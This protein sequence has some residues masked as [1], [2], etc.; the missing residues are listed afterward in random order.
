MRVK[1]V[2]SSESPNMD[3]WKLCM[4]ISRMCLILCSPCVSW[5]PLSSCLCAK[6]RKNPIVACRA[7][8]SSLDAVTMDPRHK[9]N[10]NT[11][12]QMFQVAKLSEGERRQCP[13]PAEVR[14]LSGFIPTPASQR[15]NDSNPASARSRGGAD[16][17]DGEGQPIH[18]AA[19]IPNRHQR[20]N[21]EVKEQ[22]RRTS[23]S[24]DA[25][26][27]NATAETEDFDSWVPPSVV[28]FE[29]RDELVSTLSL[30]DPFLE[31][32]DKGQH[33]GQPIDPRLAKQKIRRK[34]IQTGA[35]VVGTA[36]GAAALGPVGAVLVGAGG[37]AVA[38]AVGKH[39]KRKQAK[40]EGEKDAESSEHI[41]YDDEDPEFVRLD[42]RVFHEETEFNP[43][44][45]RVYNREFSEFRPDMPEN[46]HKNNANDNYEFS[47][48]NLNPSNNTKNPIDNNTKTNDDFSEFNPST[49][50]IY[51]EEPSQFNGNNN[52]RQ[53]PAPR[54][55]NHKPNK[56][57]P[58]P[59][60]SPQPPAPPRQSRPPRQ[61]THPRLPPREEAGS[62]D[63]ES[64]YSGSDSDSSGSS[65]GYDC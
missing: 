2:P 30:G 35:A 24:K 49:N 4:F 46:K 10:D 57:T 14:R 61:P 12:N 15:T 28:D 54:R 59:Q 1:D 52:T 44:N 34:R 29:R 7:R 5:P 45:D 22:R 42:S 11:T 21:V 17:D 38:K 36:I 41:R 65:S 55:P 31:E 56:Q 9:S 6:M 39:Q 58:P 26:H 53:P 23:R 37:Y 43:G 48:Y 33:V 60:Q 19:A 13:T 40:K 62:S 3:D 27:S 50:P 16:T 8:P 25:K 20:P 47:Q 18:R 64:D 63:S 32:V 51:I